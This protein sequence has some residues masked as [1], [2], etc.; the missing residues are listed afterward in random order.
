VKRLASVL[1]TLLVAMPAA[2]VEPAAGPFVVEE[3]DWSA[4][5]IGQYMFID[6]SDRDD[7]RGEFFDQYQ[8]TPNRGSSFPA[9]LG[10]RDGHLDLFGP[11][12]TPLLQARLASPTSNLGISGSQVDDPFFNQRIDVLS[13]MRGLALDLHYD[14]MR[15]EQLRRFPNTAGAGLLFDDRSDPDDR[16]YRDRTGMSGELRIRPYRAFDRLDA[17][18]NRLDPQLSLR[19]GYQSRGGR[20]QLLVHRDPS[21]EWLGLSQDADRSVWDIGTGLV[22]TP[23]QGLTLNFDYDYQRFQFGSSQLTEGDLGYPPPA[24]SRT[25]GFVPSTERSTVVLQMQS[26]LAERAQ[27]RAGF[28]Y[29]KLEQ[30]EDRTPDQRAAGLDDNRVR[31]YAANADLRVALTPSLSATTAVRYDRRSNDIDR[32]TA[33]F[34]RSNGTQVDAFLWRFDRVVARLDFDQQIPRWGVVTLGTEYEDIRRDLQFSA[35]SA[36]RILAENSWIDEDTQLVSVYA[37]TTLRPLKGL[38]VSGEIG[39]R[40]APSTAYIT[41]LDDQVYGKLRASYVVPTERPVVLTGF[42][43]GHRGSNDDFDAVAG[44][45]PNP[46][47]AELTRR[48]ERSAVGGGIT[49]SHSPIEDVSLFASFYG[50]RDEQETGLDLSTLQ[51]YV[52]DTV[53]IGFRNAG[54]NRY[55]DRQLSFVTGL[56]WRFARRVD[57][58]F[59]YSFTQAKGLY[60]GDPASP[61]L[62]A[63]ADSHRIDSDIHGI[64]LEVGTWLR[65][66][67]RVLAGYRLQYYDE[68]V[69]APESIASAVSPGDRD[70]YQHTYT[71]GVTLTSQFFE[72]R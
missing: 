41:D 30:I 49:I 59:S 11:D 1:L 67:M 2:S 15:T 65:K 53:A 17:P 32:N 7:D 47:G 55:H 4:T 51:R 20:R 24:A 56:H 57:T 63:I 50:G 48:Y 6:G 72:G 26:K 38:R 66:G 33:L 71:L 10:V 60:S 12:H 5:F 16:F 25:I 29:S 43:R 70:T 22:L 36:P 61:E 42:L 14:R 54:D 39:Y 46:A 9:E 27:L 64:D 40:D 37:R 62:D 58:A 19:G 34:S 52:Q 8:W 44:L 13:R 23:A 35:A 18:G 21:N 28:R 3:I 69:D 45:G 68:T 31:H